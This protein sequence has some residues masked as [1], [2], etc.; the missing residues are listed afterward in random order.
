[1]CREAGGGGAGG[2]GAGGGGAREVGAREVG[3]R[4]GGAGMMLHLFGPHLPDSIQFHLTHAFE[5]QKRER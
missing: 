2:G 5:L 3:A 4:G 1:M